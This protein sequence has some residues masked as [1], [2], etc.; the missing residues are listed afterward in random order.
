MIIRTITDRDW[1]IIL[2]IQYA[3][4]P[5]IT[6]ESEAVLRSKIEL[7]PET[8][9]VVTNHQGK[10]MAYCLAHPWLSNPAGLHTIYSAPINPQSL[11]IHDMAISPAFT[12]QGIGKKILQYLYEWAK[13]H[14]FEQLSLVSLAQA[15]S[16]WQV[17]GFQHQDYS[18][19]T[20]QYGEG[21]C[22]MLKRI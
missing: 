12:R 7:G 15:T 6:P 13:K 2:D 18:I 16:Y 21:A 1:P 3:V 9:L 22:Y 8:C 14:Y 5:N 10:V 11:Y 17:Q 4:Y 20:H 19:D